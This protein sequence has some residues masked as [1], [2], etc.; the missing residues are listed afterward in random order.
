M[1]MT[2]AMVTRINKTKLK[3][4]DMLH[5]FPL[6]MREPAGNTLIP[7]KETAGKG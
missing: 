3:S 7:M 5:V 2:T 6:Y 4:A 1:A